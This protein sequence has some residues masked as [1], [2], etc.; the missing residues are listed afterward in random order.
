M[1]HVKADSVFLTT[2]LALL[3]ALFAP[4]C[5]PTRPTARDLAPGLR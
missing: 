4:Q 1:K 5:L 3:L 2:L